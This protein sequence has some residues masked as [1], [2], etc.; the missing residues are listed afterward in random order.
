MYT[1]WFGDNSCVYVCVGVMIRFRWGVGDK[2]NFGSA[3]VR[4]KWAKQCVIHVRVCVRV[5]MLRWFPIFQIFKESPVYYST[6]TDQSHTVTALFIIAD[7][8]NETYFCCLLISGAFSWSLS[9]NGVLIQS[10]LCPRHL[11]SLSQCLK[12]WMDWEAA[13]Y[14]RSLTVTI[15]GR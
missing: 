4:H 11:W 10:P 12:S 13:G 15:S 8:W 7:F 9:V 1:G 3:A 6:L 2:D 14:S 5:C